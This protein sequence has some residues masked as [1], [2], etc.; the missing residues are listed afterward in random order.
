MSGAPSGTRARRLGELSGLAARLGLGAA[1][2]LLAWALL[3]RPMGWPAGVPA[4]GWLVG[5]V[6]WMAV[7]LG[8]VA[9]IAIQALTGGRWGEA[10]L[11]ALQPVSLLLPAFLPLAVP[12]F[13][14]LPALYPWAADPGAAVHADV[15]RLYL[16]PRG[17]VL[18]A[19]LALGGWSLLA[20]LLGLL[21]P[22]GLRRLV[23]A[24]G[25]VF[26]LAATTLLSLDWLL[27]LDPRFQSTAFGMA[28]VATQI[29][30]ALAWAAALRPEAAGEEA[31]EAGDLAAMLLAASLGVLYLG[32]A[33]YLVAWYGDLPPK[34]EWFLRRQGWG[35]TALEAASVTLSG[36][37]PIGALLLARV[38][39]RPAALARLGLAVL[40]GVL[41]HLVWIVAPAFG[42][43]AVP[44]AMLGVLAVGGLWVGLAYGPVAARLRPG[45][46]VARGA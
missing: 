31:G 16:N 41:A 15:A 45:Q 46:E 17:F 13:L 42:A 37:L 12:L 5:L 30:V 43:A 33:Q 36:L 39:R 20:L 32:F 9:L 24:L 25:L 28:A 44:A 27:S 23:A 35:W 11:P 19:L 4:A 10:L 34:A 2:A 3:A 6:F 21:R 38:R 1:A 14:A 8:A 26:H 7:S 18:R 29:L 22:G 40:L